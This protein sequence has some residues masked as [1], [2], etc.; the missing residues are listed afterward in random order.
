MELRPRDLVNR[1]GKIKSLDK[2]AAPIANA[3]SQ[4][5]KP[6]RTK[7]LLSGTWLGHALHP[8]LTDVVIGSWTSAFLLDLLGES[9]EEAADALVAVGIVSALPTALTGAN[10]WADTTGD[11]RR[12]GLVH[13]L[14]NLAGLGVYT[15]SL[16]YRRSGR[17]KTGVLLSMAGGGLM[18][19]TA[20][21]GG[22]LVYDYG[23]GVD[24][25]AFEPRV[26][27]WTAAIADE[28]LQ[29]GT[30]VARQV[31][32]V[33]VLLYRGGG[34]VYALSSRCN[35]L[36]GPL[37]QGK[38]EDGVVECPW[39]ASRFRLEDGQVLQGPARVR[40]PVWETRVKD[41]TIEVRRAG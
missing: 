39:H 12:L 34:R 4:V 6:G 21:L 25:T 16:V 28:E 7:D 9:G 20:Y 30:P 14:G 8:V 29:E 37:E 18:T 26:R 36:G 40:Q 13:G 33:K 31:E 35:H 17:R 27:K 32:G 22:H 38:I 5:V 11:A 23:I 19:I 2:I 3:Y 10:E 41:G 1:I 15:A 24:Q